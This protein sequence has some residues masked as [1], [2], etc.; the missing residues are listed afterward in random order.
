MVRNYLLR[1]TLF[2]LLF[3]FSA[4]DAQQATSGTNRKPVFAGSFYPADPD[5]LKQVLNHYFAEAALLN[6]EELMDI[7]ALIVPHAGYTYSGLVSAAGYGSISPDRQYDNIFI[8]ASSHRLSF[9]GASVYSEGNYESPLGIVEVNKEIANQLI[10]ENISIDFIKEAHENEHSIEVQIPWIQHHFKNPAKIVPIVIGS[11]RPS[12]SKDLALALLPFFNERNLFVVSSDFSHYPSYRDAVE[13]D[14]R[15]CESIL[16][17]SPEAFYNSLRKSA[18]SEVKNL[19]TPACGWA[20]ILTL[21]YMT[22]LHK[23]IKLSP[24][25][26]RNS[27]DASAGD[28]SRVVGYWAIAATFEQENSRNGYISGDEKKCLL[29]ISRITLDHYIKNGTMPEIDPENLPSRLHESTGAFVS[30]YINQRLR[31]CVGLFKPDLPLYRVVQ[32]MTVAAAVNDKRFAPVE[33]FELSTISIEIS[34]LTPLRKIEDIS[35]FVLGKHGIYIAKDGRSGTYLPQV[36][37]TKAWTPEEFIGH[38]S[39]NKAGLGWNGWRDAELYVY[40]AIV[41]GEKDEI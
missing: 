33:P 32:E 13:T 40:E 31:G 19:V 29:E 25:L 11:S 27:G 39:Q 26:Y 37:E 20:S 38:C 15:T 6:R 30:L 24:L 10:A 17:N 41:F 3:G 4:A 21:V 28:K 7:R 18:L 12:L 1:I 8:I 35:E 5:E 22:N 34:V 14:K 36:A 9:N 23:E 2:F 16:A